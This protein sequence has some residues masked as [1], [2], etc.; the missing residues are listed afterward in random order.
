MLL[1]DP[2]L[3]VQN[4]SD[5][6]TVR[7]ANVGEYYRFYDNGSGSTNFGGAQFVYCRGSNV[8]A[9][10]QFVH[11][12]N[13]SA[14]LLASA[15]STCWWPIGVAAAPLTGTAAFGWVQVQGLCDYATASNTAIAANAYIA[16][17]STAGQVGTV[18]ALGSRINGIAVPTAFTSSQVSATVYLDFPKAIG[19]TASN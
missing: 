2:Y 4:A 12:S 14:V 17:G 7:L 10:G 6:G 1:I 15:N 19:I 9:R 13:G 8:T 11:I 18:T 16:F 3:G 5:S